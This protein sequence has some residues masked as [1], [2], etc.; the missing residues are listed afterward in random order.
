ME[1]SS[2]DQTVAYITD[3][4]RLLTCPWRPASRAHGRAREPRLLVKPRAEEDARPVL[5]VQ[6]GGGLDQVGENV[7]TD[8]ERPRMW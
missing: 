5:R 6:V 8:G 3:P 4:V 1:R 2:V 7:V